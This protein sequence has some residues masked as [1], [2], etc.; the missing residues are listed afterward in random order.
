MDSKT[1][2]A[3]T[4]ALDIAIATV[5]ETDFQRLSAEAG[6]EQTARNVLR[7]L[8]SFERLQRGVMPA[9]NEWDAVFY[10][11]WYHPGHV[12]LAYTLI[13]KIPAPHNPLKSGSKGSLHVRDFGC[14]TLAMQFGLALA[15]ADSVEELR[16]APRTRIF[17]EDSS[18][19]MR[20]IGWRIWDAFVSEIAS[21]G[22][23]PELDALRR[24][25]AGMTFEAQRE[26]GTVSWLTAL[27]VAYEENAPQVEKALADRIGRERPDLV[28]VTSHP[29]SVSSIFCPQPYG[30]YQ[31]RDAFSGAVFSLNGDFS[32][33]SS[34]R[35]QVYDT[36]E[37]QLRLLSDDD[38]RFVRNYL[39]MYPT[40]WRP[41]SLRTSDFLYIRNQE[42]DLGDLPF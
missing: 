16:I 15:A 19:P 37:G 24:V 20:A 31:D 30:Y 14:G 29:R 22:Q 26:W 17:S 7:S 32:R 33:I 35:S 12:N 10:A 27:H 41:R 5:V 36:S 13:E 11:A 40:S 9:Y 3:V 42:Y 4:N 21:R 34:F 25:C 18:E 6:P 23:Y 38:D 28:V 39:K 8:R 2:T 1:L